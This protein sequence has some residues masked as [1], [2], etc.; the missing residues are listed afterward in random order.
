MDSTESRLRLE[1]PMLATQSPPR[2]FYGWWIV[3]ACVAML[4]LSSGIGFY[5]LGVFM[6]SLEK[7]FGA[8]PTSVSLGATVFF[9]VFCVAGPYF[10]LRV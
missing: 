6:P 9:V 2:V 7:E 8:S 4:T 10:G 5:G 3:A 1:E